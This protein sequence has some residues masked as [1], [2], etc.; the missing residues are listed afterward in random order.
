MIVVALAG[1]GMGCPEVGAMDADPV[2]P[3]FA[4]AHRYFESL[5]T[6]NAVTA[7]YETKDRNGNVLGYENFHIDEYRW[8]ACNSDFVLK[9]GVSIGIDWSFTEKLHSSDGVLSILQGHNVQ[10]VSF[11]ML[12]VEGGVVVD[13]STA[14]QRLIFG[15]ADDVS[16]NRLLKAVHLLSSACRLKSKFD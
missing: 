2:A 7:L 4:D 1:I 11:H 14:I 16:R 10:F 9:N 15:I 12:S 13:A 5:I 8:R 6:N 3:T